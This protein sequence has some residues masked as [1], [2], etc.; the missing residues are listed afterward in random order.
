M[1]LIDIIILVVLAGFIW[2]GVRLGL[3]EVIGGI[4]GLFVGVY[5]AGL[6]YEEAGDMLQGLLFDSEILATIL[7]FLL[8]FILVNRGIALIFWLV[9]K[10]FNII[11]IIPGLKSLNG[12]LGGIFGLIEGLIFIGI[13]VYVSS[14]FPITDMLSDK[15]SDSKFAPILETVGKVSDPFIPDNLKDWKSSLPSLDDLPGIPDIPFGEI[16]GDLNFFD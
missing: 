9:D 11:A 6:Y 15:V 13:I 3:I 14:F 16:P 10:I 7:G 1:T 2:K 4:I 12:L 5:L 8:V